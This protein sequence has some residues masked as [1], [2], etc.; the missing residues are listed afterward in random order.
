MHAYIR[1]YTYIHTY[2]HTHKCM[3]AYIHTYINACIHTYLSEHIHTY[4]HTYYIHT[5]IHT[6]YIHTHIH[7]QVNTLLHIHTYTKHSCIDIMFI[8][9]YTHKSHSLY[10]HALIRLFWKYRHRTLRTRCNSGSCRNGYKTPDSWA[11]YLVGGI[12]APS[13]SHQC[14][15][16]LMLF[17]HISNVTLC[18]HVGRDVHCKQKNGCK[19]AI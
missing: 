19:Y 6:Y 7:T 9:T 8:H 4:I 13:W 17:R 14:N 5:H 16:M 10:R 15:M 2:I 12:F 1:T 18:A 3:H 11:L